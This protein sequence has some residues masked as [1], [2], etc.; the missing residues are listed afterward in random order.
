MKRKKKK[1][2]YFFLGT[3]YVYGFMQQAL[4]SANRLIFIF[5]TS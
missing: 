4:K 3:L 1:K 2:R 5:Y